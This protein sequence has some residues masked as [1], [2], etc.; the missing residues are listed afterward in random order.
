MSSDELGGGSSSSIRL[1]AE[2]KHNSILGYNYR[3]IKRVGSGDYYQKTF[4]KITKTAS[5]FFWRYLYG[6]TYRNT[7]SSGHKTGRR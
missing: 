7:E 1:T 6:R 2:F 3:I 4:H 5:R